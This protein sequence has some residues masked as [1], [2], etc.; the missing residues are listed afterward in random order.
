MI[1][2]LTGRPVDGPGQFMLSAYRRNYHQA[3]TF[4]G[5]EEVFASTA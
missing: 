2:R 4:L 5:G 1:L 3:V